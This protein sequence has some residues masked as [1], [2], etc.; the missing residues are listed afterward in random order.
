MPDPA[1]LP[2]LVALLQDEDPSINA[3]ILE[4]LAAFGDGLA[5]E[6]RMIPSAPSEERI[7]AILSEVRR[8]TNPEESSGPPTPVAH[9]AV[10]QMLFRAGDLVRHRRYGY[11]GVI[12]AADLSCQAPEIWY[13]GNRTHP[14]RE[15]PWYHVLVHGTT[16]ITYAAQTSLK[17]DESGNPVRH[18][19][20][21]HYFGELDEGKYERNDRPWPDP[22]S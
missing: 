6:L 12:V 19:L 10:T 4:N 3:V 22:R 5:Q 18:P 15:Q 8:F 1:Q 14:P 16:T 7:T 17:A 11:R 13:R 21:P 20:M 2:H 9:Q